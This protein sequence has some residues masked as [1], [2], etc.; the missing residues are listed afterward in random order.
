MILKLLILLLSII[1]V[2]RSDV[3][4]W[5]G[6]NAI[7]QD[8][9]SWSTKKV[10]TVN[11]DATI[12]N[13][14]VELNNEQD[15]YLPHSLQVSGDS[16]FNMGGSNLKM[17]GNST[18]SIISS[19]STLE[20]V[21]IVGDSQDSN[22]SILTDNSEIGAI[23]SIKITNIDNFEIKDTLIAAYSQSYSNQL[24]AT[25]SNILITGVSL[26]V[27]PIITVNS[28]LT[29]KGYTPQDFDNGQLI[30]NYISNE[31][32]IDQSYF[33]S[34]NTFVLNKGSS[35][36][37]K[38]E[39]FVS[40]GS[41]T[42]S[43]LGGFQPILK[44]DE[45]STILVE[46]TQLCGV[47]LEMIGGSGI[48][49]DDSTFCFNSSVHSFAPTTGINFRGGRFMLGTSDGQGLETTNIILH[50]N[51]I[52]SFEK[53]N[54]VL[55]MVQIQNAN[56]QFAGIAENEIVVET[57]SFVL[58]LG[59]L[60][61]D[62]ISGGNPIRIK[63]H[64][65]I[66]LDYST[67]VSGAGTFESINVINYGTLGSSDSKST[68]N[69]NGTLLQ[70]D[71]NESKIIIYINDP[72]DF[73]TINVSDELNINNST[74]LVYVNSNLLNIDNE[75]D[76]INF[77]SLAINSTLFRVIKVFAVSSSNETE[78]STGYQV[79]YTENNVKF[80]ITSPSS[81]SSSAGSSSESS[82]ST[83][84]S[85]ESSSSN[86][87]SSESSSTASSSES[88]SSNSTSSES[89][90]TASSSES[91]SSGNSTS[92]ESSSTGSSSESSSS[93]STS[94]ESSSSNSTSSESSSSN[95]SSSESSSSNSTSSESSSSTASSSESSSSNSTSSESSSTASS[96]ESSSSNSTSS[97]SSS[98]TASSSESSSSSNSTSSESSSSD[99]SN[100]CG[101]SS[102]DWSSSDWSSSDWSSSNS[103]SGSEDSSSWESS[104]SDDMQV[105]CS[106]NPI[107]GILEITNQGS[108][109]IECTGQGDT[110][111][112]NPFFEC[113][114]KKGETSVTC[115]AWHQI[116]CIGRHIS[117]DIGKIMNCNTNLQNPT[118]GV[119]SSTTAGTFV[120]S[121]TS[122]SSISSV[123]STSSSSVTT[124]SSSSGFST[125]T[126]QPTFTPT[127][128]KNNSECDKVNENSYCFNGKLYCKVPFT[129]PECNIVNVETSPNPS[130]VVEQ[131]TTQQNTETTNEKTTSSSSKIV[132]ANTFAISLILLLVSFF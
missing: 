35:V 10:P 9:K 96:S 23:G 115:A 108:D 8:P 20:N 104:S 24:I 58:G 117:C 71:E 72:S 11:D 85:S 106:Y 42:T 1:S 6:S 53:E 67:I 69:I 91:S 7:Y 124:F 25:Q 15:F 83:G 31:L 26:V 37:I 88:S 38:G 116:T 64:L 73:S 110:Y 60:N 36:L 50:S 27:Y 97:E 76:I 132:V 43:F 63:S 61:F 95:A 112:A 34:K 54:I 32:I 47:G 127:P 51:G 68:I 2:A 100:G 84:S 109:K 101:G 81:S 122:T 78:I 29:Y 89:S 90:S 129:G 128:S 14:Y 82:S 17:A 41:E 123:S 12:D 3:V 75:F 62:S 57:N 40:I 79:V 126:F 49:F 65:P 48:S 77:K 18:F 107:K 80:I 105:V 131:Q 33:I 94:S 66:L 22:I 113:G 45:A 55:G 120:S 44:V 125:T 130:S 98:S 86:S 74:L 4:N 16:F 119:I 93:N 30:I 28:S 21:E 118:S 121:T 102:S 19:S 46:S 5:I 70:D 111:C 13:N 56:L 103:N 59:K 87:T 92:S 39:S 52:L 99:S 114:T